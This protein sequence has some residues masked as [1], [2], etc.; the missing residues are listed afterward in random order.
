MNSMAA[1]NS[2]KTAC[3]QVRELVEMEVPTV[4]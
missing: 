3:Y 2:E 1:K 4:D